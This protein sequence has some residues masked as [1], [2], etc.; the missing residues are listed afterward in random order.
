MF[1]YQPIEEQPVQ[2]LQGSLL[3]AGAPTIPRSLGAVE[4]T[5][6]GNGAWLDWASDWL[7]GS[8]TWF[9]LMTDQLPWV[10]AERPMYDRIVAVPRLI[11][12]FESPTDPD[13][14]TELA[15]LRS[16]LEGAYGRAL[17]RVGANWYRSGRDSVAYHADKVPRPGDTIVAIIAVGERRPF[18]IRPA[19]GG[20]SQRFEFGRGD[21]LVMGG[22]TQAFWHHAVPKVASEASRVS[23]MF[24]G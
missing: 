13:I 5:D 16:T 12:S 18:M 20:P 2:P 22:T 4:R 1:A 7:P 15:A 21:L 19:S 9:D 6:L 11:C 24:R 14:P 17:S 10:S 23:L 3:A 8:D